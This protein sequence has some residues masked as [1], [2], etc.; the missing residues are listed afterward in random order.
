MAVWICGIGAMG[1]TIE[2]T[3][4]AGVSRLGMAGGMRTLEHRRR[5]PFF[6]ARCGRGPDK[7]PSGGVSSAQR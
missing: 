2:L 1:Q 7:E 3:D 4:H 5:P 6:Y